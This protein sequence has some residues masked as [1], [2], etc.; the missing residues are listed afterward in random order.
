[1]MCRQPDVPSPLYPP[2]RHTWLTSRKGG[3]E[4][5]EGDYGGMGGM[6]G[7]RGRETILIAILTNIQRSFSNRLIG[8]S[9]VWNLKRHPIVKGLVVHGLD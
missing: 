7:G 9:D 2:S 1:M 6:E 5:K 4:R 8:E 3:G